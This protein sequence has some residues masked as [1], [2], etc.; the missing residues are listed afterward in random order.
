MSWEKVAE[1]FNAR[2]SNGTREIPALKNAFTNYNKKA[3]RA[4]CDSNND[5]IKTGERHYGE[6]PS[7]SA[8]QLV[9]IL[10]EQSQPY[11]YIYKDGVFYHC[12]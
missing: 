11:A 8:C 5:I 2:N 1:E 7:Y 12:M 4:R 3:R 6:M 9:S 10:E